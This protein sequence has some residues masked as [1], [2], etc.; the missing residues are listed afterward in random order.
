[1]Y[2]AAG[3][4]LVCRHADSGIVRGF[5][6]KK[7]QVAVLLQK[8][9][10]CGDTA[11]TARFQNMPSIVTLDVAQQLDPYSCGFRALK[12]RDHA[13]R[14]RCVWCVQQCVVCVVYV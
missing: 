10:N 13:S 7:G 5:D 12:V 9:Q 1:M 6:H 3:K 11:H 14:S 4:R 8:L 2:D